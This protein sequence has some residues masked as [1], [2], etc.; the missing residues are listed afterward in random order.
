MRIRRAQGGGY[1]VS[2]PVLRRAGSPAN[3]SGVRQGSSSDACARPG[4]AHSS[5]GNRLRP[6]PRLYP[7]RERGHRPGPGGNSGWLPRDDTEARK[8][9]SAEIKS[10]PIGMGHVGTGTREKR[11]CE[12]GTFQ[13]GRAVQIKQTA[14]RGGLSPESRCPWPNPDSPGRIGPV[15]SA[16]NEPPFQRTVR[17]EQP[18]PR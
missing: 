15:D 7:H 5:T 4:D 3:R 2:C 9:E 1:G 14:S 18:C 8:A 12:D 16:K 11:A 13:D 6:R 17:A 10:A